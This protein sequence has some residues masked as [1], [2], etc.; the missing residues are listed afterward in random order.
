MSTVIR[1]L[2][3][4]VG[5]AAVVGVW[6]ILATALQGDAPGAVS[7]IVLP[8]S[9]MRPSSGA[10][11]PQQRRSRANRAEEGGS[12]AADP[13][14]AGQDRKRRADKPGAKQRRAGEPEAAQAPDPAPVPRSDDGARAPVSGGADDGDDANGAD[15]DDDDDDDDGGSDD[16]GGDDEEDDGD[17]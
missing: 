11:E 8:Q 3:L 12:A 17:D 15:D 6:S 1:T 4:L 9:S 2:V 7:T 5:A 14:K 16:D 10:A 13:D